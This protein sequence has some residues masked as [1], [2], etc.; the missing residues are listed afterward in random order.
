MPFFVN[1]VLNAV[2]PLWRGE[3]APKGAVLRGLRDL[4]VR[5]RAVAVAAG[6]RPPRTPFSAPSARASAERSGDGSLR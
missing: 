4:R 1:F 6:R 5:R 2:P 3:A